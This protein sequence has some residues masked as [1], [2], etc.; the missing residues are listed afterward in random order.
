MSLVAREMS[1][2]MA[3]TNSFM[4]GAMV[5]VELGLSRTK[6]SLRVMGRG[7]SRQ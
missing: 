2:F 4:S 7:R 3:V 5:W 6:L 1:D